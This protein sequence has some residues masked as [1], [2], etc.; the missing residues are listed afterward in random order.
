VPS[1]SETSFRPIRCSTSAAFKQ[2]EES[3]IK[4]MSR[5]SQV[6]PSAMQCRPGFE[7]FIF[8]F[9]KLKNKLYFIFNFFFYKFVTVTLPTHRIQFEYRLFQMEPRMFFRHNLLCSNNRGG[10]SV[11]AMWAVSGSCSYS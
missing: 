11:R 9:L 5:S 6:G 8:N 4:F 1:Y 7:Q 3:I 2:S 10:L